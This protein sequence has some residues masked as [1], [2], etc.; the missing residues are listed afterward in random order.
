MEG[1]GYRDLYGEFEA[2]GVEIVGVSFDPPRANAAWA[3]DEGF[4]FELWTDGPERTLA[5]TYGAALN[6]SA[7]VA[8]RVTVLLD[9][10]GDLQL[11]YAVTDFGTHPAQVLDDVTALYGP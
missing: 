3:E 1:C 11:T 2:L 6:P 4:P 8:L 9:P 10:D 7:A 5:L